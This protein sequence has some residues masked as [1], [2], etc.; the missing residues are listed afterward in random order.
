MKLY[1]HVHHEV[2]CEHSTNINERIKYIKHF[3]PEHEQEIRLRLM[4]E[5]KNPP[6]RLVDALID[7][8]RAWKHRELTYADYIKASR[9]YMEAQWTYNRAQ[10]GRGLHWIVSDEDP[11]ALK[12]ARD[13]YVNKA[14]VAYEQA[15][16]AYYQAHDASN[17][18]Q[19][20]YVKVGSAY[21]QV[22]SS[23][24][25][26]LAAL[27]K[28]ECVDCPWDGNTIFPEGRT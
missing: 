23:C 20:N 4:Q 17:K 15:R 18:A 6:A 26:E 8:A 3:K 28:V 14:R 5:V 25:D 1:W 22:L 27:H 7:Y 9:I 10:D 11:N 24:K 19:D 2:L 21:N 16:S 13:A 12:Q